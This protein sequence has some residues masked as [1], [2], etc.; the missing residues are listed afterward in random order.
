MADIWL[1]EVY[2]FGFSHFHFDILFI[3]YYFLATPTAYGNS[4][5][6][7]QTGITAATLATA[8]TIPDP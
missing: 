8:M 1:E 7:E 5:A 4:W 3:I 6:K 2:W